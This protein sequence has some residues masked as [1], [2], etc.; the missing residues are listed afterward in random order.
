MLKILAD[1]SA[2]PKLAINLGFKGGTCCYFIHGLDRFSV[3]LDFDLLNIAKKEIVL[4]ELDKILSKYGEVKIEGNIFCRKVKYN[5]ESASIKVDISDRIDINK[6]NTYKLTDIVS[7]AP[8]KILVKEDIFAHKLIALVERYNSRT[9]NKAIA[10]RDL[11]DINYFFDLGWKYNKEIITLRSGK[12]CKAYFEE[13]KAVI[14]KNV[15]EKNIL[16]SLGTLVDDKKRNWVRKNLKS[17]VIKKLS[18]E[19]EALD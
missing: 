19:I 17:E 7:G 4:N 16:N 11:Y 9:K 6:L 14:E 2:N 15:D 1:I 13:L 12:N 8:M 5:D 10:N 18:I 3:D